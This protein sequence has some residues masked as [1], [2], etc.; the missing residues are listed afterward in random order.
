VLLL[1][2]LGAIEIRM[3]AE[4]DT[5]IFLVMDLVGAVIVFG[6]ALLAAGAPIP[7]AAVREAQ[8]RSLPDGPTTALLVA[9]LS[10]VLL[11]IVNLADLLGAE[12]GAGSV[13]WTSL[14]FAAVAA[15]PGWRLHS[16]VSALI[17]SAALGVAFLAL[18][19]W[20]F[21]PEGLTTFRY[22]LL[23]LAIAYAAVAFLIHSDRPRHSVQHVSAAGL[24]I[25]L[26]ASSIFV[27][28]IEGVFFGFGLGD[29]PGGFNGPAG[30]ELISL[31]G[32]SAVIAYAVAMR[33]PGPGYI[34]AIGL[35]VAT[36]AA[37]L[38]E[39]QASLVGWPLVLL[40]AALAA[41]AA[42]V[43]TEGTPFTRSRGTPGAP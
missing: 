31:I 36:T 33:E 10:F 26:L 21:D 37:A 20:I 15:Y 39:E 12:G 11:V 27:P 40:V 28:L 24:A 22:M 4:W 25:V 17:S 8:D 3:D 16:P 7:G 30:W 5:G 29:G 35:V 19:E 32:A 14:L 34:G 41:V 13:V 2:A 43:A 23:L 1:L 18:I 42:V 9:G 6:W 38:P